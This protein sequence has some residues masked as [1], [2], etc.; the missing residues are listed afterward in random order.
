MNEALITVLSLSCSATL[1][2][3][4][5]ALLR[6]IW[7]V[8]LS[9]QWQYYIWLVVAARLLVPF[10]VAPNLMGT[11]FQGISNSISRLEY[12]LPAGDDTFSA[13]AYL[14]DGMGK[15]EDYFSS[16]QPDREAG[17]D[18]LSNKGPEIWI[19]NNLWLCWLVTALILLIRKITVYQSFVK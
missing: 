4:L 5:L 9:K 10:A 15:A 8:R 3:V 2:I 19:W 1:L 16:E 6:P 12:A 11:F 7:R 13:P 18:T 17:M 14:N